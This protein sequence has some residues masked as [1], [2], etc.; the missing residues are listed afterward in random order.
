[1]KKM[2]VTFRILLVQVDVRSFQQDCLRHPQGI[3]AQLELQ[4]PK[5]ANL[6]SDSTI[7]KLKVS[8]SQVIHVFLQSKN[9]Y[10]GF[11]IQ[12]IVY[13]A[14]VWLIQVFSRWPQTS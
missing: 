10:N 4:L 13:T 2:L 9:L 12:F 14:K 3:L 1:M 8:V 6:K 5:L 7:Q 11:V